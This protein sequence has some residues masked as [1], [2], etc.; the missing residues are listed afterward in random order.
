MNSD[1]FFLEIL[2]GAAVT[3]EAIVL[4]LLIVYLAKESRRRGLRALDWFHLPPSMALMLAVLIFDAGVS[5]RSETIWEW[6]HF[7]NGPFSRVEVGALIVGAAL[8]VVGALCMIRAL[9]RPDHGDRP[10]LASTAATLAAIGLLLAF[11]N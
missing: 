8:I 4:V 10:W 7:G 9:T 1:A 2:N 3:P 11:R 5:L 6:R